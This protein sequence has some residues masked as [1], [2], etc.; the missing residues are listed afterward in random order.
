M[1][2]RYTSETAAGAATATYDATGPYILGLVLLLKDM[3][4]VGLLD[5]SATGGYALIC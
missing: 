5:R 1:Q 4:L 3:K 2:A